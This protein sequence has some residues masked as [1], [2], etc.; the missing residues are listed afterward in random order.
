MK[1]LFIV[2]ILLFPVCGLGSVGIVLEGTGWI[3]MDDDKFNNPYAYDVEK[4]GI[5]E[6]IILPTWDVL[7]A[8]TISGTPLWTY[9]LDPSVVCPQ[10]GTET[11]Y[12]SVEFYEFVDTEP[13][14]RDAVI[15]C[16]Y[17]NWDSGFSWSSLGLVSTTTGLLRQQFVGK[18][19]RACIDLDDDGFWEI[20]V[21]QDNAGSEGHFEVWGYGSITGIPENAVPASSIEIQPNSP[22]PFNP[23]TRLKFKLPDSGEVKIEFFDSAGRLVDAADL[24]HL[25][26]GPH[27]YTWWGRNHDGRSLPSG[28]YF[29]SIVS[30]GQR[31]SRKM[32]LLK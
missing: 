11:E 13:G 15:R 22:N 6:L 23:S 24:G 14:Q 25:P 19:F 3:N 17:N 28:S 8:V 18:Y 29:Y 30:Q 31:Q 1:A 20:L 7:Q 9:T 21:Q 10:C 27:E 32:L 5:P 26:S 12:W 16:S 2:A 4:D